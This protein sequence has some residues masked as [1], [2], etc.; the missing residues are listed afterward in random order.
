MAATDVQI[1]FTYD[2]G[3]NGAHG[4][5]SW[6][7]HCLFA[8]SWSSSSRV[9]V[10]PTPSAYQTECRLQGLR[11]DGRDLLDAVWMI[12][13]CRNDKTETVV[14]TATD[15]KGKVGHKTFTLDQDFWSGAKREDYTY[16]ASVPD[17]FRIAP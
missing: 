1:V 17:D 2:P 16:C 5:D 11:T 3:V 9:K 15:G 4:E 6:K 12:T 13:D 10:L 8:I 14:A 7:D